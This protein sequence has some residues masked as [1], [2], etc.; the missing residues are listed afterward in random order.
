MS[1]KSVVC[2]IVYTNKKN[3]R[4]TKNTRI[5]KAP[6][7]CYGVLAKHKQ[8]NNHNNHKKETSSSAKSNMMTFYVKSSYIEVYYG[9]E[10]PKH[11]FQF[12]YDTN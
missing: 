10:F 7:Y 9:I 1:K 6:R 4:F 2:F 3:A 12:N 11:D 5:V 8:H